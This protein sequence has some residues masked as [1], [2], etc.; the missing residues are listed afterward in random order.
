[1]QFH[2]D[3]IQNKKYTAYK[4]KGDCC[5]KQYGIIQRFKGITFIC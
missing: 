4:K 5:G 3:Y 1:M 2:H